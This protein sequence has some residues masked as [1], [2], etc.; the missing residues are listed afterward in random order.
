MSTHILAARTPR[1]TLAETFADTRVMTARQL[2]KVL[3]RPMYVVYLF[4]Q[5]VILVLLFRYVFGGAINVPGDI[6]YAEF[7]LPGIFAQTVIFGSTI[8]GASLADDLQKGLIDRFRSLPMAHSAVLVG[9]T[10]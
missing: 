1:L 3:R 6:S 10:A 2:R 8:T 9:R 7:L 4:V 5:P